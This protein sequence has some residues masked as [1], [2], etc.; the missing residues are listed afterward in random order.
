MSRQVIDHGAKRGTIGLLLVGLSITNKEW[1]LDTSGRSKPYTAKISAH[2]A[3]IRFL[4]QL[5][6]TLYRLINHAQAKAAIPSSNV[7]I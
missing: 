6:P 3:L 7:P 4:D 2:L 5:Q 1:R